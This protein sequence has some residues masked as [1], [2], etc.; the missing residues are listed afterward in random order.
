MLDGVAHFK[1]NTVTLKIKKKIDLLR[2]S[3]SLENDVCTFGHQRIHK[4]LYHLFRDEKSCDTQTVNLL[5]PR[6]SKWVRKIRNQKLFKI[7]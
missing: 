2:T 6:I 7:H 3:N 4:L 5:K 1:D